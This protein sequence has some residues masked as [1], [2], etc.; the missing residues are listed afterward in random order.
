MTILSCV[1]GLFFNDDRME[2]TYEITTSHVC[3]C[4]SMQ[5]INMVGGTVKFRE[6]QENLV[7]I[8]YTSNFDC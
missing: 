1:F 5:W 7:R 4:Y 2:T 3:Y 6:P 8:L